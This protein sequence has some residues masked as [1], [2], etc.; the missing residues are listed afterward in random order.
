MDAMILLVFQVRFVQLAVDSRAQRKLV[1][2]ADRAVA[3]KCLVLSDLLVFVCT[4]TLQQ[5][6]SLL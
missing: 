3:Q 2:E 4:V 6:L 1:E 5:D